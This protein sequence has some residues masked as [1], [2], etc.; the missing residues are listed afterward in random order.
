MKPTI[1]IPCRLDS[2]RLPRKP[3]LRCDGKSLVQWTYDVAKQV[4]DVDVFIAT[5]DDEI[6]DEVGRF[7]GEA[8]KTPDTL[9]TGT[10]R[11]SWVIQ[12]LGGRDTWRG[13]AA[14][15]LQVDEPCISAI[16]LQRMLFELL[17]KRRSIVTFTAPL[18][19]ADY[20][21]WNTVKVVASRG[22]C[23]WFCRQYVA[24]SRA[25][26]GVYGFNSNVLAHLGSV[27]VTDMSQR[28]S[29]E[30]LS[31]LENGFQINEIPLERKPVSI[32]CLVDWEIFCKQIDAR[33]GALCPSEL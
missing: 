23:H 24:E 16:E 4:P 18:A 10:H 28:Q 11:T 27:P 25:H 12:N 19:T 5:A 31:W 15:S 17:E 8:I 26:V 6:I 3:L 21:D 22:K 20:H 32:N 33:N 7:G 1:V 2:T 29:L 14:I 9:P 30:Q 13:S